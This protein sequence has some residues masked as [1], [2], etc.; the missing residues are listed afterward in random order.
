MLKVFFELFDGSTIRRF[1]QYGAMAAVAALF[2]LLAL[3]FAMLTVHAAIALAVGGLYAW[4]I[5]AGGAFVLAAL[6]F[7]IG[8]RRWRRRP[9]PMLARARYAMATEAL[10]LAGVLLRKEPA[11]VLIAAMV[12]GAIAEHVQGRDKGE[13]AQAETP[14]PPKSEGG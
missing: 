9:R 10:S 2:G 8:R 11:K 3:V 4:L 12:L 5:C 7:G 1:A 6:L 14:A 13:G